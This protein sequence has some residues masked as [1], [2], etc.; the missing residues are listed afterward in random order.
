MFLVHKEVLLSYWPNQIFSIITDIPS[1][2]LF[3]D[4]CDEARID[5]HISDCVVQATLGINFHGIRQSFQTQ[6]TMIQDQSVQLSLLTGPFQK[7]EG[8]WRIDPIHSLSGELMGC[9]VFFDLEYMF[10]NPFLEKVL[11]P[12]FSGIVNN[13]VDSFVQRAELLYASH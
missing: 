5:S 2:P 11:N 13:F 1:Y 7:L 8:C 12:V 3:L 4:W 10:S 6:N 9:R